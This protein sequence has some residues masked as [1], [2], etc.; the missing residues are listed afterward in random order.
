M[1]QSG[2]LYQAGGI[3]CV[4]IDISFWNASMN[5][6]YERTYVITRKECIVCMKN[7]NMHCMP[8]D[9]ISD[10]FRCHFIL[11]KEKPQCT[12]IHGPFHG[13]SNVA[14]VHRSPRCPPIPGNT[15]GRSNEAK[16]WRRRWAG[17]GAMRQ[18]AAR[19]R[20]RHWPTVACCGRSLAWTGCSRR[21]DNGGDEGG[22]Q[23][24][25]LQRNSQPSTRCN[26]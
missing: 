24:L 17:Q 6:Q 20:Q 18:W 5:A 16:M 3:F 9:Q 7:D 10:V 15:K 22:D 2:V 12:Y 21:G 14:R 23:G 26:F 25:A 19:Q 13:C 1:S 8:S 11:Q 4:D